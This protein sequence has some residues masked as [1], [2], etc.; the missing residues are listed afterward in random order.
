MN[1]LFICNQNK[2][3]SKTAEE[4]FRTQFN[5]RSAGLYNEHPVNQ[6]QIA[7]ADMIVVMEDAQRTELAQRFPQLYL[8]KRIVSLDI[9]DIYFRGQPELIAELNSKIARF[10]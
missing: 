6:K 3:R 5:T 4:I 9:P 2:H 1:I 7:W 8:K 10:L